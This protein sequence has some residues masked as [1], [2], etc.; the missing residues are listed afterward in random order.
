MAGDA[1]ST[2]F[3]LGTATVMLGTPE[4]LYA[5][6]PVAHSLGLVKNFN[7]DASKTTTDLQGG[8]TNEIIMTL[9]TGAETRCTFEMYEYT[10]KNIAY[11]LGLEGS[12]LVAVSGDAFVSS[13][14]ATFSAGSIEISVADG[15]GQDLSAGDTVSLRNSDDENIII[16]T[17]T[18]V[19]GIATGTASGGTAS[20][21]IAVPDTTLATALPVGTEVS[22]VTSLDVGSTDVDRDYS[23]KITGQLANGKWVTLLFPKIRISSGLSMAFSTDQFGNIPFEFKPL[24][25]SLVDSNYA[26]FKGRSGTISI[27][28]VKAPL[29]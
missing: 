26:A 10:E 11:A 18:A 8:R 17:V 6:N 28:S 29:A 14:S 22:Q 19:S 23:A 24:K 7:I 9:T 20:I 21:T 2:N 1:K 16:G 4:E 13:S 25:P 5:L 12:G 3:M 27:D 15:L